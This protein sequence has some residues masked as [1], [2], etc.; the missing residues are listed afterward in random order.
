ML[1]FWKKINVEIGTHS[2]LTPTFII[3]PFFLYTKLCTCRCKSLCHIIT[4]ASCL[5]FIASG[6]TLV[7]DNHG[8][9]EGLVGHVRKEE[10]A[11]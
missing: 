4:E 2:V 7:A 11:E 6:Y 3:E 10:K 1:L 9:A 8:S 5:F